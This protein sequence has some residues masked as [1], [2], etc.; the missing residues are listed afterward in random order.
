LRVEAPTF[1]LQSHSLHSD[2]ALA[3]REVVQ[4]AGR[5]GV[6]LLSLT[7]HDTADGIQEAAI[8]A[9]ELGLRLVPGVEISA[10]ERGAVGDL[11]I[12]GYLIDAADEA[13][14][15]RL[16]SY[17]ADRTRRADAMGQAIRELGFQL[18]EVL[19]ARRGGQV[20]RPPPPRSSGGFA[21][22]KSSA[23]GRRGSRGSVRVSGGV[24]DRGPAGF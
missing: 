17:R 18:D 6:E 10:I 7:D 12:L 14:S 2:G 24:P 22:R 4:A 21:S 23:I 16:R 19:L 8:A 3:P 9:R 5:A 1:D 15:E 20:D 13:L 11:H